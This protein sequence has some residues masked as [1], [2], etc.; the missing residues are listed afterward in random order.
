[1][2]TSRLR[3]FTLVEVMVTVT[4]MAII[5]VSVIPAMDMVAETR[6]GTARDEVIRMLEY[7]RA[8][9]VASGKPCGVLAQTSGSTVSMVQLDA[10]G[11]IE[12][13]LNPFGLDE[14]VVSI[15]EEFS[16]VSITSV[17][18]QTDATGTIW[19]DYMAQPHARDADGSFGQLNT[20]DASITLSSGVE[21]VVRAYS[22]YVEVAP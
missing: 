9:A 3:G 5:A 2:C 15:E 17:D 19:F 1:M 7:A 4:I 16:G 21:I 20:G 8:R 22:G 18:A 12:P 13:M 14:E 6:K 11:G 10:D